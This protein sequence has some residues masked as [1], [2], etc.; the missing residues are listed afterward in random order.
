MQKLKRRWE[1]TQNWQ[2]IYIVLGVL[3]LLACGFFV[4]TKII[5]G[6]FEDVTYEYVFVLL[7]SL[8]FAYIFYRLCIWLF[9]KLKKRWQVT[10][11][12][13]LIA[14]FIVFAVTGSLSARISGPFM[15]WIGISS[16]NMSG[17]FFWPM[18]ILIIFPIYQIL[19]LAMGWLF[20]QFDFFWSFEK[21]MLSRFGLKL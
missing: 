3:G 1:I 13:E 11:R 21:K 8:I 16:E 10:Y 6:Y 12:W 9:T 4:A 18:R 7:T 19:L 20:G 2:L 17:W 5:P 14:I 15:E